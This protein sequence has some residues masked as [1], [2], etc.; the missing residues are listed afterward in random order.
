MTI[1][2]GQTFTCFVNVLQHNNIS[3]A[4]FIYILSIQFD[5]FPSLSTQQTSFSYATFLRFPYYG[6]FEPITVPSRSHMRKLLRVS[7][8]T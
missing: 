6:N 2:I 5:P 1:L 8:T 7:E 4:L 3:D